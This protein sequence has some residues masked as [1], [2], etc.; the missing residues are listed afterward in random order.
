MFDT[1]AEVIKALEGGTCDVFTADQ[2]ALYA[3]RATL[4][5]P[6]DAVILPDIISKEPLG[7]VVRADDIA[8]FNS[9]NGSPSPSS[10]P[11]SSAWARA[12]STRR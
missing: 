6:G 5:K 3:E 8:W 2:S 11:R 9:S 7:P 10:T 12:I 1:V 4:A